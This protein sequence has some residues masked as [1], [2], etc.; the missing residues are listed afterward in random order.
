MARP[1][2]TRGITVITIMT[3]MSL[4]RRRLRR[5]LARQ[6]TAV[7]RRDRNIRTPCDERGH[8]GRQLHHSARLHARRRQGQCRRF[9][10]HHEPR[11]GAVAVEDRMTFTEV[12]L[13]RI[14]PVMWIRETRSLE[15]LRLDG[16]ELLIG[17]PPRVFNSHRNLWDG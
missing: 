1:F 13:S 4:L 17:G 12:P 3:T 7:S 16:S 5:A 9:H 2:M 8:T 10:P 15:L 11:L 6:L 14:D